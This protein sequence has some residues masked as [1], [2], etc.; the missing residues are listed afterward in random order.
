MIW[1]YRCPHCRLALEVSWDDIN[2]EVVCTGC[3][4]VHYAPT[5]GEDHTAYIDGERWPSEMEEAV[6]ALHGSVCAVP[7]CYREHTTLV[8]RRPFAKGGRLS[9]EN[10]A[11][12]CA[13]HASDRGKEDYDDWLARFARKEPDV[14]A[15]VITI[16]T[17]S[18]DALPVQTFG[19]ARGVQPIA[20]QLSLPGPFPAGMR[21]VFVAP[22]VP[23]PANR[24]VL[25]YEW[26][27]GPGES[28]RV[29]L[30]AWPRSDQPD[31]SKHVGDSKGYVTNEH[32]A[33]AGRE[34]SALL[35]IVLSGS[36]DELWVAAVWVEAEHERQV[37][38]NYYL[39]ATTDEPEAEE[40]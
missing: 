22:F 21:L 36:G 3:K 26:K 18:P 7:G 40:M 32:Q 28:C 38:T 35:E 11:P 6:V 29:V 14:A 37:I 39:A 27:L 13:Q 30:G 8:Q 9:V 23:G 1:H 31:F 5:P 12:A 4:A 17:T 16:T 25:Y 33:A 24:L 2:Q 20:G 19:Q 15:S 10:L 34:S